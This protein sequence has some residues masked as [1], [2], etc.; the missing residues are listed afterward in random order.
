MCIRDSDRATDGAPVPA[1][2]VAPPPM[3]ALPDAWIGYHDQSEED[4]YSQAE[5]LFR[6]MDDNQKAQLFNNIA[7][8]LSTA[9]ASIQQRML[10]QFAKA[11]PAYAEGVRK[12]LDH[13]KVPSDLQ[14]VL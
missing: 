8:G 3:P 13:P 5:A 10:A 12:A 1:P 9:N 4:Y 6:I 14:K 7:G 11:D 2:Q